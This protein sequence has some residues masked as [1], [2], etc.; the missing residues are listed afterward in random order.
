VV[1]QEVRQLAERTAKFTR[2]IAVKIESVQ[3]G[4]GRAVESMREGRRLSMKGCGSSMNCGRLWGA[5]S[6]RSKPLN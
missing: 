5:S 3:Q 4:A 2:E 1:A 6:S